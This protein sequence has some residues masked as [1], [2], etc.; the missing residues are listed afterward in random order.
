MA[1]RYALGYDVGTGGCKA[2]LAT[3]DGV[4]AASEFEPYDISYPR[5]HFAEQDPADW[6]RAVAASTRRLLEKTGTDPSQIAG[7]AFS[8]QMLGVVAMDAAGT[9]LRPGII[10]MDCRA[11]E[12]ARK[13]VRKLGGARVM[14]Q[15]F[16]AVPS[17]KDVMCKLKWLKEEEPDIF[18]RTRVF[19]D[20]KGYVVYRATG[21]LETDQT[22]ASVTGLMDNKTRGW[23]GLAA[24]LLGASLERMP[25][26]KKS[27]DVS[28]GL[29]EEAATDLGLLP[30]TPVISGMGDA[31]SGAVGAGAIAHG[32]SSISIGTS[33]LLCI[34]S[35]K[36]IN[37]GRSGMASIAAAD[38]GMWLIV[39][40]TNTAGASLGW[41]AEQLA[42]EAER[43]VAPGEG[44]V[45]AALDRTVAGVPAGSHKVIFTPWM[46]GER[47]PVTDTT[48]RGAFINVSIDNTR[49]DMLRAVYEGVAMNFRWMFDEAAKRDLPCPTV[50]AIGGGAKSDEWMQIFAD[51]TGRRIEAVVKPQDAGAIGAAL[52]V[53]LGLGVYKS[54]AEVK[55]AVKVRRSFDPDPS[56]RDVYDA[57]FES[58]QELYHRLSPAY[59]RLNK[60]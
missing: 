36:R 31:P 34:T 6:W 10:W 1:E 35:E 8:S 28:G 41:F 42:S 12:Q 19:L 39:G 32:E 57:L 30:G 22:A 54:Y 15:L 29:T 55:D 3:L 9:P 18:D 48:L 53:P 26:V 13:V 25:E 40:E 56:N 45:M 27:A 4:N 59:R 11:E 37:L 44:G 33:G 52:A 60:S 2:V 43:G 23:S 16:G 24:R 51:V 21:N 49:E 14:L 58:F 5:E 47:A 38:P 46:Y 7:I 17:G 20:V 50:R